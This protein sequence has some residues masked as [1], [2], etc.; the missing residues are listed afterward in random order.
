MITNRDR[1]V[2]LYFVFINRYIHSGL[3]FSTLAV[4]DVVIIKVFHGLYRNNKLTEDDCTEHL[5]YSYK[6]VNKIIEGKSGFFNC[7]YNP[8]TKGWIIFQFIL[9]EE[10][11]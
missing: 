1:Q 11:L 5:A 10:L 4:D 8:V 3:A 7:R 6:S 2:C 9:D